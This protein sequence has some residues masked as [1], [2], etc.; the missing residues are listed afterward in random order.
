MCVCML[1]VGAYCGAGREKGQRR[2]GKD[3]VNN[4]LENPLLAEYEM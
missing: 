4:P 1:R 2:K 3:P